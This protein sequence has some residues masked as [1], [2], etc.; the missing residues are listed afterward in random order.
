MAADSD[1]P[2]A[3]FWL[4]RKEQMQYRYNWPIIVQFSRNPANPSEF[5]AVPRRISDARNTTEAVLTHDMAFGD[6]EPEDFPH[7]EDSGGLTVSYLDGH[8]KPKDV[9]EY[10]EEIQNPFN[11]QL[12]TFNRKGWIE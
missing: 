6:W 11:E 2:F 12:N 3:Q 5:R 4:R 9:S 8:A 7:G 10:F 1:D